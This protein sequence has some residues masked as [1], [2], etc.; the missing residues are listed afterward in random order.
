MPYE[1]TT[2]SPEF[3][4]RDTEPPDSTA[5]RLAVDDDDRALSEVSNILWRER[6]LLELLTF[7]LEEEQLVLAAGRTRWLNHATR[8]VETVL[9]EIKRVELDRAVHVEALARS[10]GL[11]DTPNLRQVA[12]V[13]PAPWDR[14]FDEHR[15]ALLTAA[16]DIDAVAKSNRDLLSRGQTATREAL[17]ALGEIEIDAYT[18]KGAASER[19]LGMRLV[20]EAI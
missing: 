19:S 14:I 20:D 8:E 11:A 15:N 7:K 17:A 6:Q 3:P 4:A 13:V 10:L 9:G 2:I 12:E 1:H 16:H 5:T 18:P